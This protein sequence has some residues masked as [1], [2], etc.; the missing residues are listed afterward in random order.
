MIPHNGMGLTVLIDLLTAIGKDL[1]SVPSVMYLQRKIGAEKFGTTTLADLGIFKV[2]HF[3][4]P[5]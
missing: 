2:C 1:G 4:T 3:L 5:T